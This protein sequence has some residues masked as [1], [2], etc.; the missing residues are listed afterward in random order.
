MT[1]GCGPREA[2]APARA[3]PPCSPAPRR[4]FSAAPARCC[5]VVPGARRWPPARPAALGGRRTG[6]LILEIVVRVAG[7]FV[8]LVAVDLPGGI[9]VRERLDRRR[10]RSKSVRLRGGQPIVRQRDVPSRL[11]VEVVGPVRGVG[12][13]ASVGGPA[14]T[15]AVGILIGQRRIRRY[16]RVAVLRESCVPRLRCRVPPFLPLVGRLRS[17]GP[18]RRPVGSS[19]RVHRGERIGSGGEIRLEVIVGVPT[20]LLP[21]RRRLLPGRLSPRRSRL[22]RLPAPP[23]AACSPATAGCSPGTAC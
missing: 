12:R 13:G 11:V 23:A 5:P 14:R 8:G 2:G 15:A 4:P 3:G 10:G 6:L 17:R 21:G 16:G 19:L 1:G 20:G 22:L 18:R 7:R 9:Q